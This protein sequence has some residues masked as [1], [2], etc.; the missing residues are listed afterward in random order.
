MN[1][2]TKIRWLSGRLVCFKSLSHS[3]DRAPVLLSG[4][5]RGQTS[6]RVYKKNDNDSLG[7][8]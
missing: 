2:S 3:V 6:A 1:I 5:L 7:D 8:L 4:W